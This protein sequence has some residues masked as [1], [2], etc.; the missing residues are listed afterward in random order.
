MIESKQITKVLGEKMVLRG[1]DLQI[2][3]GESV[4][5]LGANGAGKST[6]LKIAAGL[7][8]PTSGDILLHGKTRKTDDY[9]YQKQIGYLGHQSFLY[10]SLSPVE[11]LTFF[12]KLYQLEQRGKRIDQLIADVGLSLFKHEPVRTFSRGMI[13]RLAIARTILHEPTILFLDEPYTGL[14][15]QAVTM[16]NGLL[17]ELREKGVTIVMVTHDFEYI[18]EV[19]DRIVVLRKGKIAEDERINGRSLNWIDQLYSGEAVSS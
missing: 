4:A 9:E 11:N 3:Q 5:I 7:L 15:K 8:K 2:E 6:W 16:F 12:A 17:A 1:I 18:T 10:D 14:D 19:C 13:Q